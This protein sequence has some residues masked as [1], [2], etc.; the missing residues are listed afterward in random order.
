M[1]V[2]VSGKEH[3]TIELFSLFLVASHPKS[4]TV[5]YMVVHPVTAL[6]GSRPFLVMSHT[7]IDTYIH[8]SHRSGR[9]SSYMLIGRINQ[10][11][12]YLIL[13]ISTASSFFNTI[14]FRRA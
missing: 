9:G 14:R 7:D 8:A 11:D 5:S 10:C 2:R 6:G 12:G 13:S 3:G 4:C 1:R